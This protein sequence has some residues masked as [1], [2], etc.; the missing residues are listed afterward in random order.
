M[1]GSD[2]VSE[3][4]VIINNI[5]NYLSCCYRK[6]LGIINKDDLLQEGYLIYLNTITNF[7]PDSSKVNKFIYWKVIQGLISFIRSKSNKREISTE[8][9][10]NSYD[11]DEDKEFNL[12][13]L[14]KKYSEKELKYFGMFMGGY[15]KSEIAKICGIRRGDIGDIINKICFDVD[16]AIKEEYQ[17]GV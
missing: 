17:H 4:K 6:K 2:I 10:L 13:P 15:N 14:L 3:H 16:E 1:V 12:F 9:L 8:L 5:A 7:D 11:T